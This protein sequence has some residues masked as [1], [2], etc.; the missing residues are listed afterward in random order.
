M[1][2]DRINTCGLLTRKSMHL[3]SASCVLCNDEDMEDRTHLLFSCPFSQGFWWNLG[4]E[5]NTDM[6]IHD[7]IIAA[8]Q[9]YQLDFFMEIMIVGSWSI[10]NQRNGWIFEGIPCS[11]TECR[12]DFNKTFKLTM[13]RA[14]PSLKDGMSSWIDNI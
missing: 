12:Y 5:W 1:L 7:L 13:L 14:K 6:G 2:N 10:W 4:I 8:K 9:R 3:D 11:I